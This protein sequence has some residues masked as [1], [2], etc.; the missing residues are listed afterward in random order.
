MRLTFG[1]SLK[2]A[3]KSEWTFAQV[4][5]EEEKQANALTAAAQLLF[6]DPEKSDA[7]ME[8]EL[9]RQGFKGKN[10]KL[11]KLIGRARE[12]REQGDAASKFS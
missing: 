10:E 11:R 2:D 6:R 4:S 1:P 7:A 3:R 8:K 12:L 9:R 5:K